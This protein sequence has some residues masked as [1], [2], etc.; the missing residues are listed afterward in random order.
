MSWDQID[1]SA[2]HR[3]PVEDT[4][5]KVLEAAVK[6]ALNDADGEPLRRYLTRIALGDGYA[7]GR[8][9]ADT[10]YYDGIRALAS[11]LLYLGDRK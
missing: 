3:E 6:R 11:R 4:A 5:R 8:S 9:H 7:P 10:A 2:A 1:L